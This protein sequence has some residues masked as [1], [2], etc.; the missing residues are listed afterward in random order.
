MNNLLSVHLGFASEVSGSRVLLVGILVISCSILVT[1]IVTKLI[2][3]FA[4][5]RVL[6]YLPATVLVCYMF[7]VG[8]SVLA[9]VNDQ[10]LPHSIAGHATYL[11]LLN[12]CLLTMLATCLW[13]ARMI[14][15]KFRGANVRR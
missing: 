5:Y 7:I 13:C 3:V 1:F 12:G 9:L 4:N 14:P 11:V 10:Y 15:P 8:R 2:A 6:N